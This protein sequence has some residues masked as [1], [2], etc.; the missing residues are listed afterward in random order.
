MMVPLFRLWKMWS[1]ADPVSLATQ[2][3][4]LTGVSVLRFRA[5]HSLSATVPPGVYNWEKG[6][7]IYCR[8]LVVWGLTFYALATILRVGGELERMAFPLCCPLALTATINNNCLLQSITS[9]AFELLHYY[10]TLLFYAFLVNFH[11]DYHCWSLLFPLI[12]LLSVG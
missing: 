2:V 4:A 8:N 6:V 10:Y 12:F 11:M 9:I 3:Q 5:R 1:V 7:G